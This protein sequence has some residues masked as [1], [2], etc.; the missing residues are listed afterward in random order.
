MIHRPLEV[1][2]SCAELVLAEEAIRSYDLPQQ[3]VMF[4]ELSSNALFCLIE[5]GD[6]RTINTV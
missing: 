5:I 2:L 1:F 3:L 4:A 6:S